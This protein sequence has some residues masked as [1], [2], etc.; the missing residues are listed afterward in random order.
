MKKVTG[1]Q[2]VIFGDDSEV[3][4]VHAIILCTG[5][6]H[7]FPFLDKKIKLECKSAEFWIKDLQYSCMS[8]VC[9]NLF[10]L[11]MEDQFYTNNMFAAKAWFVRD[12]ILGRLNRTMPLRDTEGREWTHADFVNLLTKAS[13]DRHRYEL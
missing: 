11:G 12:I 3:E 8:Q 7:T 6:K 10:F 1:G 9:P 13:K 2:T 4:G 5:Y